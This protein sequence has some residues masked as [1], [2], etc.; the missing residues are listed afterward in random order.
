MTNDDD[1]RG[2]GDA[3]LV[4]LG[5]TATPDSLAALE[6]VGTLMDV[7]AVDVQRSP[8]RCATLERGLL[9]VL[10]AEL[11]AALVEGVAAPADIAARYFQL[12]HL[13]VLRELANE[14]RA[15]A[16]SVVDASPSTAR[17]LAHSTTP[18]ST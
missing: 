7:L 15:T 2:D 10:P 18:R 6:A 17:H 13:L 4:R 1:T 5:L 8:D 3:A 9:A 12:R 16:P 11:V 14:P